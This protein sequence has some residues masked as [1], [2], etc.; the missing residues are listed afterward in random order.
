MD[1]ANRLHCLDELVARAPWLVELARIW[2]PFLAAELPTV[3]STAI[4][5]NVERLAQGGPLFT[6]ESLPLDAEPLAAG[7]ASLLNAMSQ[8]THQA[9]TSVHLGQAVASGKLPLEPLVRATLM[10]DGQA[11]AQMA[12]DAGLSEDELRP[13]AGQLALLMAEAVA[14]AAAPLL[15][16][17]LQGWQRAYCPVCGHPPSAARLVDK[18]GFRELHCGLC[19]TNWRYRRTACP[20]CETTDA[21]KLDLLLVENDRGRVETCA[22]CRSYLLCADERSP[23]ATLPSILLPL[24]M[25]HL[26]VIA[27]DKGFLPGAAGS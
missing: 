15:E 25:A 20:F 26:D 5:A 7:A 3:P 11:L 13:F 16:T 12:S 19:A 1:A 21:A 2:R 9:S 18:E 22:A 10:G 23:G 4:Q 17:H 24:S 14:L 6:K 8:E 27:Q